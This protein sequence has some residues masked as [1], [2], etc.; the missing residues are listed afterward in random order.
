LAANLVS[1]FSGQESF[2]A[3]ELVPGALE[4]V[5]GGVQYPPP[6]EAWS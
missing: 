3:L 4:G 2:M 6:F 1:P 5:A